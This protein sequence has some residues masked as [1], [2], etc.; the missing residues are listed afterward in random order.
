MKLENIMQKSK[1][2][3]TKKKCLLHDSIYMK[4]PEQ[5][6]LHRQKVDWWLTRAG[7]GG[8]QGVRGLMGTAFLLRKMKMF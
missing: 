2:P 4:Y 6:N 8:G 7:A 5:A 1:K 3:L